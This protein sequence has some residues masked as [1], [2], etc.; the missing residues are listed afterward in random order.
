VKA[1]THAPVG[2]NGTHQ[3]AKV[4]LCAFWEQEVR[5]LLTAELVFDW[6]GHRFQKD[7]DKWR[8]C[9]PWHDSKSGTAFY[10]NAHTLAW[11]CPGCGPDVGGGPLQYR[12]RLAG[13]RGVS[14]RGRDFVEEVRELADLVGVAFPEKQLS[15]QQAERARKREERRGILEAV[16]LACQE[17]LWS[18]EGGPARDYVRSRGFADDEVRGLGL[19]LYL[20]VDDVRA[21]VRAAG[22]DLRLAEEVGVFRR[23]WPDYIV[24]PWADEYGQLL[25][26]YGSYKS[27]TPPA[28]KPKKYALENPKGDGAG[29]WERTKRSPMY[30]DRARRAG[31]DALVLVEGVT[32]AALAQARGDTSVIA[33]VAAE[34]SQLRVETLARHR[35]K[36][37]TI[38]LDPDSAGD[39]GIASCLRALM[40]AGIAAY[41]APQLPDG[42]DPDEFI[43]A[44]GID[45]WREH[46]GRA[47]HAFRWKA[48]R[49]LAERG[50][51]GWTDRGQD[52]AIEEA[53]AFAA[54]TPPGYDEELSRHLLGQFVDALGVDAAALRWRVEVARGGKATETTTPG[55][56]RTDET[57]PAGEAPHGG[58]DASPFAFAWAPIDSA[59]M[60]RG[61]FRPRW[62]VEKA[63]VEGEPCVVGAP[64]KG[65]KT[66]CAVDLGVSLASGTPWLGHFR[67]PDCRRVA[68]V[69]GE[70]GPFALQQTVLRVC[71]ARGIRL[72]D[73][74]AD[75][76]WQFRLPQLA[77]LEQLFAL[78]DGLKRDRVEVA[79]IDPLYLSLLAGSSDARPENLFDVGP[80][81]LR[82]AQACLSVGTTP[83]LLHHTTKPSA[84][85]QEPLDL[86]DL[87]FS[88]TAE[89][90]RQWI[91]LNRREIYEPDS[92]LHRLWMVVGGSVGHSGLYGVDIDEGTLET[93]FSGRKWEVSVRPGSEIRQVRRT[94]KA[95]A[96]A[97][98]KRQEQQADE[99]AFLAALRQ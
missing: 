99:T 70:S 85:K 7:G 94:S 30:Y 27:K 52:A 71:A 62:L 65:M 51:G 29:P 8:G 25:T 23:K 59:A 96:K 4:D 46:V 45:A 33:C 67:V 21:A 13:G 10:L 53:V 69:S 22:H 41:V 84:R 75:L 90:A 6:P 97:E 28:G 43:Q 77:V 66:S 58:A 1:T 16:L 37:V 56:E 24:F 55:G 49:I 35:V 14:P 81:L 87:A 39:A 47:V 42:M 17:V 26:L 9:R 83:A 63:L 64:Q 57:E 78:R 92:G 61:D 72:A 18:A 98:A 74:G 34:L 95:D 19:G 82:V 11:R 80:L 20:R 79:V 40:G 68:I 50:K 3:A 12:W 32:D 91:L 89:F 86:T 36:A 31:H 88:G 93:D 5:P 76:R 48:Q 44:R 54:A 73:L 38:C 60:V 15:P 2:S